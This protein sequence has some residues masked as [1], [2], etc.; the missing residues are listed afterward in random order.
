M[1]PV[2]LP[3]LLQFCAFSLVDRQ[4]RRRWLRV[5]KHSIPEVRQHWLLHVILSHT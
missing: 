1:L 2:L 4:C 3:H 5:G